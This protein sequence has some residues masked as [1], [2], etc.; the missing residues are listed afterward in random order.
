[1]KIASPSVVCLFW[2][3]LPLVAACYQRTDTPGAVD[4]SNANPGVAGGAAPSAAANSGTRTPTTPTGTPSGASDGSGGRGADAAV[5][6]SSAS[7][8]PAKGGSGGCGALRGPDESVSADTSAFTGVGGAGF[9]LVGVC[10]RCGWNHQADN[11]RSLVYSVPIGGKPEYYPCLD[12]SLEWVGC[13]ETMSCI[14]SG[15]VPEPCRQIKA[16]LD[17]CIAGDYPAAN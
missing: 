9:D 13:L 1:L 16:N 10:D 5:N 7:R 4:S 14:C 6:P 17:A 15:D 2:L 3:S 11:C 12:L 8:P